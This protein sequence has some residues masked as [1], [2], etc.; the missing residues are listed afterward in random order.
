MTGNQAPAAVVTANP[1]TLRGCLTD[2]IIRKLI[3]DFMVKQAGKAPQYV[4]TYDGVL[5]K[6][7]DAS[8]YYKKGE[9]TVEMGP[10][11][12]KDAVVWKKDLLHLLGRASGVLFQQKLKEVLTERYEV[13][14]EQKSESGALLFAVRIQGPEEQS[15]DV[16]VAVLVEGKIAV[17]CEDTA[18]EAAQAITDFLGYMKKEELVA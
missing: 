5:F 12:Y 2:A 17:F 16:R 8:V 18:P 3:H 7:P 11:R 6:L 1:T 13:S 9:I 10:F 4:E 14:G 15:T